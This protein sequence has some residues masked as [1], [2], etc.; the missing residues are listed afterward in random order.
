MQGANDMNIVQ[1]RGMRYPDEYL[2]RFFYKEELHRRSGR[3]LELGC[4]S[5]NNLMHFA[6]YGWDVVGVDYDAGC[7]A[8]A[9]HNLSAS[10]LTGEVIQHDLNTGLPTLAGPFHA[11]L[12]PSTLYYLSREAAW[13][14]L[15]QAA[16]LLAPAAAFYLRMR[17]PDD[18]RAGR[19]V[20]E[21]LGAW[22]L[23]MNYTGEK[24]A[25][26]VFWQEYE[27]LELL[28]ETLGLLPEHLTILRVAYE[29]V[30]GGHLIRNSDIV[31]WGRLP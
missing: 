3:A 30:Q 31:L 8:D 13:A 1:L 14:S 21:G 10:N 7:V 28:S 27:L 25:L 23:D 17:L 2:I 6:A 22:R 20:L 11:L 4:G 19:G 16:D 24:G 29:N 9:R 26:N 12:V 18:H 15:K 5:A